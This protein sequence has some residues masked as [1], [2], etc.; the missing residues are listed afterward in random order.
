MRTNRLTTFFAL[1]AA[2]MIFGCG[3]SGLD[4]NPVSGK[5]TF[6]G[7]PIQEG[8]ITFR[9]MGSDPRAFS[10]EIKNGQYQMEAV[11][12]KMKVEIIASRPVPGKFDESNPGEKVPV[13]EMYIPAKYNSQSE[14]TAEV[15][16]G[17]NELN[18][19]LTGGEGG[20]ASA[21]GG[22]AGGEA[23]AP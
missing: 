7:Q 9:G 16:S 13:G 6:D 4:T 17:S 18:F 10:A 5:V 12:G 11:A 3:S 22:Q 14:L 19:D 20:A 2:G 1:L 23:P 21:A 8:R 15:T